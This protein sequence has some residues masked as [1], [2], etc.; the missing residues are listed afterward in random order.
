MEQVTGKITFTP[1]TEVSFK[2]LRCLLNSGMCMV[3]GV[4]VQDRE[5]FVLQKAENT[6]G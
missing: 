4:H 1:W 5:L 6:G 3:W 2:E